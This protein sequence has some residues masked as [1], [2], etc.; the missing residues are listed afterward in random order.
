VGALVHHLE[1]LGVFV[2]HSRRS[3]RRGRRRHALTSVVETKT[4]L[5]L[6][7]CWLS[8]VKHQSP[9]PN[10]AGLRQ[11]HFTC[12]FARGFAPLPGSV[13]E[14]EAAAGAQAVAQD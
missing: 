9:N 7:R 4:R 5:C 3:N 10:L 6:N 14:P 8:L 2:N 13:V 1:Q 11:R 12:S